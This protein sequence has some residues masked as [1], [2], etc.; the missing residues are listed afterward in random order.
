[1][2]S[3]C[4]VVNVAHTDVKA[5][6]GITR[7]R[8]NSGRFGRIKYY[9]LGCVHALLGNNEEC[10]KNLRFAFN[11]KDYQYVYWAFLPYPSTRNLLEA[12]RTRST[13]LNSLKLVCFNIRA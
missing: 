10:C 11:Y 13:D 2:L 1:M 3:I 6:D 5:I 4:L 9:N 7:I 12:R 8:D